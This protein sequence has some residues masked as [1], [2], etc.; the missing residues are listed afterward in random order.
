MSEM[1]EFSEALVKFGVEGERAQL[2]ERQNPTTAKGNEAA[3]L[4]ELF[5]WKTSKEAEQVDHERIDAM[6]LAS[7]AVGAWLSHHRRPGTDLL[8]TE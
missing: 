7:G 5:L 1:Q 2:H 8:R 4:N 3:E 6:V